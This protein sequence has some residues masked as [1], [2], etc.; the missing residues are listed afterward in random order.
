MCTYV[1]HL[2]YTDLASSLQ[3]FFDIHVFYNL[4]G[5]VPCTGEIRRTCHTEF[6]SEL[7]LLYNLSGRSSITRR[8]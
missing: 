1:R 2:R 6:Y 7:Q 8:L 5:S 3:L 4:F